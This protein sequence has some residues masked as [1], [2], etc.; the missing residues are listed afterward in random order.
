MEFV[1]DPASHDPLLC[2]HPKA[3]TAIE[4]SLQPHGGTS[5]SVNK[6]MDKQNVVSPYH[7]ILFSLEQEW[8]YTCHSMDEL[9][10]LG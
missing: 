7:G 9:Y 6:L 2:V 8:A 10:T 5:P 4:M 1:H 3:D